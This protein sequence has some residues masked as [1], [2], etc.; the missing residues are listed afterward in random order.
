[1]ATIGSDIY[2]RIP[3]ES[4]QRILHPG[5]VQTIQDG[6]HTACFEEQDVAADPGDEVIIYFERQGK[7]MQQA[8]RV[9]AIAAVDAQPVIG[10]EFIGEAVSAESRECFRVCTLT[11]EVTATLDDKE[12][13]EVLDISSTGF[14]VL[15][16]SER[17]LGAAVKVTMCHQ[18]RQ[19]NGSA[20][21]KSVRDLGGGKFRYGMHCVDNRA[22]GDNLENGLRTVSTAVQ[23]QQLRRMAGTG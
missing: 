6:I 12:T 7:F 3:Q 23:R 21:I 10:F 15:S 16:T 4:D 13:C 18:D 2:L 11:A 9:A 17:N 19:F 8:A 22:A 14:A 1:M 5:T 20:S